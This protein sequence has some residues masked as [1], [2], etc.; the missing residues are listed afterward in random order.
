M[1]SKTFI[2]D[3]HPRKTK[4]EFL[5]RRSMTALLSSINGLAPALS[6]MA[7]SETSSQA[8]SD[9]LGDDHGSNKRLREDD[10]NFDTSSSYNINEPNPAWIKTPLFVTSEFPN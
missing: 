9:H 7:S 4:K 1:Q 2:T 10:P 8:G 3:F 6:S 5:K